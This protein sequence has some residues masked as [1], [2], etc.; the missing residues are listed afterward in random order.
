MVLGGSLKGRC[1]QPS[2]LEPELAMM[3]N[4]KY[5]SKQ[6]GFFF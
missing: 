2:P 1:A 4:T 3:P 6:R 5:Q